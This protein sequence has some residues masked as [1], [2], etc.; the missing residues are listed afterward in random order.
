MRSYPKPL[1][2]CYWIKHLT[3]THYVLNAEFNKIY[4][5]DTTLPEWLVTGRTILLAKNEEKTQMKNYHPI[6]CQNIT[7]KLFTGILNTFLVDHCTTTNIMTLEQAGGKPGSW[8]CTDQLLIN[9]IKVKEHRGLTT[10]NDL[11]PHDWIIKALE[12]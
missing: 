9:K 1:I 3:T 11:V 10:K 12:L 7:Y 6:T 4:N 2:R 5:D 8:G